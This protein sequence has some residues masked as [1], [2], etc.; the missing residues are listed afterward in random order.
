MVKDKDITKIL[1]LLPKNAIYYW[2]KAQ[3]P[4]ALNEVELQLQAKEF[5]LI[6][7]AFDTVEQAV[8][9]AKLNAQTNDLIFI[10][11]STFVVAEAI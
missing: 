3:L 4:R 7:F 5:G 10:G 2:C 8:K 1:K 6:G 11:G 9:A